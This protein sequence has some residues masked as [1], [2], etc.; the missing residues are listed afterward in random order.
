MGKPL[1]VYFSASGVTRAAAKEFALA[2]TYDIFELLP[3]EPYIAADLNWMLKNCRATAEMRDLSCRPEIA[4]RVRRIEQYQEI[5][6][7]FPIWWGREPRII[8]T[9]LE[10]YDFRG[11]RIIPHC[12]SGGSTIDDA[13]TRIRA[14]VGMEA[15]VEKGERVGS[16]ETSIYMKAWREGL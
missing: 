1:V 11:K 10:S 4:G 8:D 9:F 7:F 16:Q 15:V 6:L 2:R 5:H 3:R 13:V 14:L 12:T